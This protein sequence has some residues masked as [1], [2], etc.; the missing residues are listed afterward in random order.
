[1][2][3]AKRTTPATAPTTAPAMTP[4]DVESECVEVMEA[5]GEELDVVWAAVDEEVD[6]DVAVYWILCFILA[7]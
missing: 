3:T 1:M 7:I 4:P 5:L 2:A 6:E